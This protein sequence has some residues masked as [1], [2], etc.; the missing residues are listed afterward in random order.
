MSNKRINVVVETC[1][2]LLVFLIAITLIAVIILL[3]SKE[4]GNAL[5]YFFVG[6]F[7][8]LRRIGNIITG[9]SPLMFTAL[10]VLLIFGAGQFS[11]IAEGAFF[12]GASMALILSASL[13]LP[14]VLHTLICILGAGFAGMLAAAVPAVLK[15][16]W[17]VSEVV[18]SIMLNYII[19]FFGVYLVSYHYREM[20]S[21]ALVSVKLS[22][23]TA[24]PRLLAGTNIH[25]GIIIG[26]LLCFLC[27][28]MLYRS[29]YGYQLRL[30]GDNISFARYAGIKAA[31]VI[32]GAQLLAGAIAGVGGSIELLGMYDR[33]KWIQTPG[34][35]WAG[36]VVALLARNNP[37]LVPLSACFIAYINTGANVMSMNSDVSSEVANIIQ[38][39]IMLLSASSAL[40]KG[41]KQRMI[42][43][44]A[45]QMR[46]GE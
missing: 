41:W 21:S 12:I 28:A 3:V 45:T 15:R 39:V 40:L 2:L 44:A 16:F 4:P 20:D 31:G 7:Q 29:R 8:S 37:M 35:G 19:Q 25:L 13:S 38:G 24:L 42:E 1:K 18:T 11:M 36:I 30:T 5:Y 17:S 23:G 10:A 22:E 33:F 26:L 46:T 6:P 43:K 9:A 34:Y 14:P 32:T 27:W